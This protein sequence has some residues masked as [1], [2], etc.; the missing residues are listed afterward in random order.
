MKFL[1]LI[2]VGLQLH[3]VKIAVIAKVLAEGHVKIKARHLSHTE[4][5]LLKEVRS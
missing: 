2:A 1:K 4:K 3:F 5:T